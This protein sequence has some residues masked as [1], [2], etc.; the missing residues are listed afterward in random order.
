M[1]FAS[2]F[3]E[4]RFDQ[5]A[6]LTVVLNFGEM[7]PLGAEGS[8]KTVCEMKGDELRQPRLIAMWQI[9]ALMPAAKT[10]LGGFNLWW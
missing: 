2:T 4:I 8:W 1:T 9:A 7:F 5:F 10:L 3:V 6:L